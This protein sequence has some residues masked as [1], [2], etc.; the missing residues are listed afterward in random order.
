MAKP[1]KQSSAPVRRGLAS[2]KVAAKEAAD[3]KASFGKYVPNFFLQD[4]ES[5]EGWFNG[6]VEEPVIR[7]VHTV[8]LGNNKWDSAICSKHE[9]G[10]DG[11]CIG[12]YQNATGDARV[13][14][15]TDKAYW[16]FAD[17]RWFHKEKDEAR[18]KKANA[19][20]FDFAECPDDPSC[21][22]C[23]KKIPRER[24]GQKKYE[25][26]MT[27]ASVVGGQHDDLG[28]KCKACPKGKIRVTGYKS[29]K[30]GKILTSVPEGKDPEMYPAILECTK[31]DDPQPGSMFDCPF[32][33]K[34]TGKSTATAYSF[35]PDAFDEI[36]E[37]VTDLE[38]VD[39]ELATKP[40]SL[41]RQAKIYNVPNPYDTALT[42]AKGASKYSS[43]IDDDDDEDEEEADDVDDD[44]LH[45]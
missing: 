24:G 30:T 19:D 21:K 26:A 22:A 2:L 15:P 42:G 16:N 28:R 3:N 43:M 29:K 44:D 9:D 25:M 4:G 10:F 39:L 37:W 5:A 32:T 6:T 36:P 40:L 33:I 41:E 34:R 18:S 23:K 35:V 13:G 11:K 12:C 38:P 14:K 45:S 31:C 20:R 17:A 7:S 27:W 8:S 1:E